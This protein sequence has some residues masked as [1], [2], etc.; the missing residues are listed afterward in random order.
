MITKEQAIAALK[1]VYDPDISLN[2]YDMGLIYN[3]GIDAEGNV[4]ITMTLT[5]PFCPAVDFIIDGV[6]AAILNAG[7]YSP[8]VDIT[9]DPPW[10]PEMLSDE[11]KMLLD[12]F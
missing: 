1:E 12:L 9:F 11:G 7:G 2:I 5:S 6:K 3:I 8:N 4:D 10:S